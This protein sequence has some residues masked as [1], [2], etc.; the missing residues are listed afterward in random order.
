MFDKFMY[1]KVVLTYIYTSYLHTHIYKQ[2]NKQ[3]SERT[4]EQ[5][6]KQQHCFC[7]YFQQFLTLYS[8]TL[9]ESHLFNYVHE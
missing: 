5:T 7:V 8:K 4:N 1:T 3:T 9:N 6:N 2:T